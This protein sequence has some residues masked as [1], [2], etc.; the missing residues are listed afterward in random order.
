MYTQLGRHVLLVPYSLIN[1]SEYAKDLECVS[2]LTVA[3]TVPW[4]AIIHNPKAFKKHTT[5]GKVFKKKPL[6][7]NMQCIAMQTHATNILE[8]AHFKS[9]TN[10]DKQMDC[11]SIVF[12]LS[13]SGQVG[14][15][16]NGPAQSL[17]QKWPQDV[18]G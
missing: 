12:N 1:G 17:S 18:Q 11:S 5:K 4:Q 10:N 3:Q 13:I 8:Q 7:A 16:E 2:Y 9:S 14:G 15:Q 6:D